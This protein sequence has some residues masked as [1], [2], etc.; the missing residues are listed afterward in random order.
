MAIDRKEIEQFQARLTVERCF[1]DI[2]QTELAE[3]IGISQPHLSYIESGKRSLTAQRYHQ[4]NEYFGNHP[5]S[6][7]L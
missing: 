3:A 5:E 7:K 4:I 1:R 6:R 2:S